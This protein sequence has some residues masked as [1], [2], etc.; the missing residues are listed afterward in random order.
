LLYAQEALDLEFYL[1][2]GCNARGGQVLQADV[3]TT[4]GS[5][6]ARTPA[7][8]VNKA[9]LSLSAVPDRFEAAKGDEITWIILLENTGDGTASQVDVNVTLGCGLRMVEIDSPGKGLNWSY[10]AL[11][12][13][14]RKT[15]RLKA[16]ATSPGDYYNLINASWGCGPCQKISIL[17]KLGSRTAI[18]KEPDYPRSATIGDLVPYEISADLKKTPAIYGST[19]LF[20]KA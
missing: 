14:E 1:T 3:S 11:E 15:V 7:I 18:R 16:M 8:F 19:I 4:S 20:Q 13:G 6:S 17:S 9:N 10:A 12:P 5:S 2:A